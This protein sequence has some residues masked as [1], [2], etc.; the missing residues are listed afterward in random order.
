V[1]PEGIAVSALVGATGCWGAAVVPNPTP[2]PSSVLLPV[3]GRLPLS[4]TVAPPVGPML[5]PDEVK[6]A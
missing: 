1:S 5:L 4:V 2:P 6:V 3:D